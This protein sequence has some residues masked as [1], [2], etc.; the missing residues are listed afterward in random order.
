[1][2]Y[3]VSGRSMTRREYLVL[4]LYDPTVVAEVNVL[5]RLYEEEQYEENFRRGYTIIYRQKTE[6]V[7]LATV[8]AVDVVD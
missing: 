1:V 4:P 8:D 5:Y 3:T 2:T 7:R 6:T